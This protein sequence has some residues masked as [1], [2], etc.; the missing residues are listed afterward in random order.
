MYGST[1]F[2]LRGG[3]VGVKFPEKTL[4]N[5]WMAPKVRIH[6][7]VCT[8][9]LH[10]DVIATYNVNSLIKEFV[11]YEEFDGLSILAVVLIRLTRQIYSVL[12]L[13]QGHCKMQLEPKRTKRKK[14]KNLAHIETRRSEIADLRL[15][16][17]TC[18]CHYPFLSSR[19]GEDYFN[20]LLS[21][22]LDHNPHH[23][24]VGPSHWYNASCVKT[25]SQSE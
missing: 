7:S 8:T 4:R 25:S 19:N 23:L 11:W 13:V 22:Y 9:Y 1:L 14:N 15:V 12:P 6:D 16:W 10:F 24:R 17:C 21:P 20:K 3:C 2:A 18:V 5:T